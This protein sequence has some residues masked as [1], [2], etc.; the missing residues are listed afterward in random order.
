VRKAQKSGVSVEVDTTGARLPEY[1][2]LMQSSLQ[3]WATQ[4]HEPLLLSRLRA[5]RRA[6]L[7]KYQALAAAVPSRFRL[8]LAMLE[9]RPVAGI[10]V[11]QANTTRYT[12]GAMVKELAGPVRANYLLH[13]TAIED[14]CRAGSTHFDFGESGASQGLAVYKTRFGSRP[15]R[16][17]S[18]VIERFPFTEIDRSLRTVVKRAI[19]FQEPGEPETEGSRG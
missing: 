19:R 9:G 2:S 7:S 16:Y 14:A 18:Y 10:V 4:Q 8:Y 15:E 12:G 17:R 1:F 11:Y 13:R 5:R 6:S 3:R